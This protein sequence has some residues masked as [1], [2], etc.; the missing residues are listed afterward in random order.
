MSMSLIVFVMMASVVI[1]FMAVIL[2]GKGSFWLP[3]LNQVGDSSLGR[4]SVNWLGAIA[5]I[6]A[7]LI[8]LV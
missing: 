5:F 8:C 7:V 4:H 2:A 6:G 1:L 3:Q